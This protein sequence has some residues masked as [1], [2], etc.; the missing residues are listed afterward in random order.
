LAE[1]V[2][3]GKIDEDL[4]KS[5]NIE[6]WSQGNRLAW[7]AA[8]TKFGG[9]LLTTVGGVCLLL[10]VYLCAGTKQR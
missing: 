9:E 5:Q 6:M 2:T 3:E 7:N 10:G 4:K 1:S 8:D